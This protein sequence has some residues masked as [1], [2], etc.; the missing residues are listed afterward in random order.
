MGGRKHEPIKPGTVLGRLT[1]LDIEPKLKGK[2]NYMYFCKC[3]CGN[4][5]WYYSHKIKSG[6]TTSCGCFRKE[7]TAK[8]NKLRSK[9][10]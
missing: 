10:D 1:V 8:R 2:G 7:E 5:G 3:S 6:H 4:T 9:H